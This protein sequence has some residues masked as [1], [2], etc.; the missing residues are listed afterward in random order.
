MNGPTPTKADLRRFDQL[1]AVGCIAHR[2]DGKPGV[3]SQIHHI[4]QGNHQKTLPLCEWHH[5]GQQLDGMSQRAML[6]LFGPSLAK[7]KK[8]FVARYGTE[9]DLLEKVNLLIDEL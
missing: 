9:F 5:V 6:D 8:A 1:Q 2:L 3:P 7:Q 4:K